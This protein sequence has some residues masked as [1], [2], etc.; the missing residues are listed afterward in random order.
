VSVPQ[1][2]STVNRFGQPEQSR[3]EQL[4]TR[5]RGW[6]NSVHSRDHSPR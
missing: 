4:I 1:D 6:V 2:C 5:I 3:R